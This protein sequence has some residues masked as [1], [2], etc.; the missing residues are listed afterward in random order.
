MNGALVGGAGAPGRIGG[1]QLWI[2][3]EARCWQKSGAGQIWACADGMILRDCQYTAVYNW[4]ERRNCT[5][6][7]GVKLKGSDSCIVLRFQRS[8]T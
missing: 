3:T 5:R 7:A 6:R 1:T 2:R 8:R 4:K